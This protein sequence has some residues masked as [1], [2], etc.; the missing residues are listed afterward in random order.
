MTRKDIRLFASRVAK[1]AQMISFFCDADF[2]SDDRVR[3]L[4]RFASSMSVIV[5]DI[6]S[7]VA[8]YG[9]ENRNFEWSKED[10]E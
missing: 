3:N 5:S 10:L 8:N 6:L 9:V 2:V 7:E 4:L 1:D